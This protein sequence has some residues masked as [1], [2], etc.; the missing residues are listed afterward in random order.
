MLAVLLAAVLAAPPPPGANPR[1]S[2]AVY[3]FTATADEVTSLGKRERGM[4][5]DTRTRIGV[6][7]ALLPAYMVVTHKAS[8]SPQRWVRRVGTVGRWMVPAMF[9]GATLHNL[10][11]GAR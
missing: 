1:L 4:V 7:A 5:H 10:R 6:K 8:R 9:F 3:A 11:E 2:L